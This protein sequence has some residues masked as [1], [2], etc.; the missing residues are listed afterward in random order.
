MG[1][2][3]FP[4]PNC[5]Q[6]DGLELYKMTGKDIHYPDY[7]LRCYNCKKIFPLTLMDYVKRKPSGKLVGIHNT[8]RL[9]RY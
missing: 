6:E 5:G 3:R 8:K 2:D 1:A 9:P 7:M 4:C